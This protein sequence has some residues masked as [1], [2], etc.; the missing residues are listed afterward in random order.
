M[1]RLTRAV[2][3]SGLGNYLQ[4]SYEGLARGA[5]AIREATDPLQYA[6]PAAEFAAQMLPGSGLASGWESSGRGADALRKGE[7]G[8]AAADY[9]NMAMDVAGE[10]IPPLKA[11]PAILAGIGAA[12]APL[13]RKAIAEDMERKGAH[14]ADI[15]RETG[16]ER[17]A[18]G[19]WRFEIPDEFSEMNPDAV[20]A[21]Q[22]GK[23]VLARDLLDHPDLFEAYPVLG[24]LPVV[25]DIPDRAG[26]IYKGNVIGL[27]SDL[28]EPEMQSTLLHELQHGVQGAEGFAT[29]TNLEAAQSEILR[30]A[31]EDYIN[32]LAKQ[33][34]AERAAAG[35]AY[36]DALGDSERL[37][38]DRYLK[39]AGEVEA[40]NVQS[41]FNMGGDLLRGYAPSM[42]AD[43]RFPYSE[44][45]IPEV[46]GRVPEPITLEAAQDM[47]LKNRARG[48]D[49]SPDEFSDMERAGYHHAGAFPSAIPGRTDRLPVTV[50]AGSYI[51]PAD[52]VSA[53]GE[54]NTLAGIKA[55]ESAIGEHKPKFATGGGVK[56]IA[57]GG[58]Y[59][60]PPDVVK[61]LGSGD[62]D[63]GHD[64]LDAFVKSTRAKNI[65]TLKKLPGP[66]Q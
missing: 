55:L 60:I 21:F 2:N 13:L 50:G 63:K 38:R 42:T 23:P 35:K 18:D 3:E 61:K 52:V 65:K 7:Y 45:I 53:L 25:N 59:A 46:P 14:V 20:S 40:R 28:P 31:E 39:T 1:D 8:Q 48:G 4:G 19:K 56:I 17:G 11:A 15:W 27:R 5:H 57:A 29:G 12:R 62:L 66:A 51:L 54:G 30:A 58:E 32:S 16:W 24:D 41:R 26:G 34:Y 22:Q 9:A 36:S 47:M 44:Q 37:G 33:S 64:A 10:V 49:V 43:R 6:R